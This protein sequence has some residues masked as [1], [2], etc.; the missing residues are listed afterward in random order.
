MTNIYE[1]TDHACRQC[2]GPIL[3]D[4]ERFVCGICSAE[5][6]GTVD[7]ICGCGVIVSGNPRKNLGF[8]C[9]PNPARGPQ[10]PARIVIQFG[11]TDTV[12]A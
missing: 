6:T 5:S 10:S 7:E 3:H 12:G 1:L 4:G 11:R 2:F 8:R 9:H